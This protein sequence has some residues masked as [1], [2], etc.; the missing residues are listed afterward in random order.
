MNLIWISTSISEEKVYE[1]QTYDFFFLLHFLIQGNQDECL[2]NQ[3][4]TAES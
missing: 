2:N 3:N 4:H 1:D